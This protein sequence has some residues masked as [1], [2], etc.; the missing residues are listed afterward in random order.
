VFRVIALPAPSD[1]QKTQMFIQ[2]YVEHFRLPAKSSSSSAA[3]KSRRRREY[4]FR[5]REG[6]ERFL[7]IVPKSRI[8]PTRASFSL[9]FGWLE[10]VD[11]QEGSLA[12]A[13]LR[14][15]KLS[16]MV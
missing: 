15:W 4:G 2:H 8:H 6:A 11:E 7:A 14:Q 12:F 9:N 5:Q 10:A 3:G 16:P 13:I 1:R